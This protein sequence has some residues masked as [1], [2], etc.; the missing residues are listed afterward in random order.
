MQRGWLLNTTE[1]LRPINKMKARDANKISQEDVQIEFN[2]LINAHLAMIEAKKIIKN[3]KKQ[4]K[5][6]KDAGI[7]AGR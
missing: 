4:V 6:K 3:K 7:K 2:N 1:Q 5:T